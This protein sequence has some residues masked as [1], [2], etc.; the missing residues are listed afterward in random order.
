MSNETLVFLHGFP[1]SS[2]MWN[3]QFEHFAKSYRVIAPDLI[4]FGKSA[5][6][7]E[8]SME[9]YADEVAALLTEHG[10]EK[11]VLIGFSMG[12]YVALAFLRKYP[13]KVRAL[14]LTDTRAEADS[15]E[16]R[17]NRLQQAQ[18]VLEQG[19]APVRDGMLPKLFSPYTKEHKPEVIRQVD[20][21]IMSAPPTGVRAALAAMASRPDSVADLPQIRVPALVIV[22]E[23]DVITP[24]EAAQVMA[25]GIPGAQLRTIPRAGHLSNLE[26][27]ESFN[28]ALEDFLQKTL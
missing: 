14:V 15:P 16:A 21:I 7:E 22:G 6:R 2:E 19:N 1:L 5:P 28:A 13:E 17:N 25:D 23:D 8:V 26:Q 12:G 10:V 27:P 4:G 3:P 9:A 24:L 11:A 18:A 20:E